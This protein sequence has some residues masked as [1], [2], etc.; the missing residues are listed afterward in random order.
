M[1]VTLKIKKPVPLSFLILMI[2]M[3]TVGLIAS[4]IY[5]LAMPTIVD[6]FGSTKQAVQ[7]SFTLY[8]MGLCV[9]QLL[10]GA[11]LGRFSVKTV[12]YISLSIF[13]LACCGCAWSNTL[14]CFLICRFLQ[15]FGAGACSVAYRS[16]VAARYDKRQVAQ[17]L[18]VIFP[19][20]GLSLAIAPYL[21]AILGSAW[22][23]RTIFISTGVYGFLVLGCVAFWLKVD[24]KTPTH[25]VTLEMPLDRGLKAY[26]Q[27]LRNREFLGYALMVGMAFSAFRSYTAESPFIFDGMGFSSTDIG[28]LYLILS[29]TYLIGNFATKWLLNHHDLDRVLRMGLWLMFWGSLV[30]IGIGWMAVE[31]P[32]I[33]FAAMS[34]ITCSNGFLVPCGSAGA[35]TRVPSALTGIAAAL[36]GTTQ[37]T[38]AMCCT[39]YIGDIAKGQFFPLAWVILGITLLAGISYITCISRKLTD[40]DVSPQT[41]P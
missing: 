31:K 38:L 39:H 35:L 7:S 11:F 21:G 9:G 16:V 41:T 6:D 32:W 14:P 34:L 5:I 36:I 18:A 19:I 29:T 27:L 10:F 26:F 4:D 40:T 17:I 30:M 33:I 13:I 3:A 22:G 37:L 1:D 24:E 2:L 20:A 12:L 25:S 8:L 23:W 15:A 28:H